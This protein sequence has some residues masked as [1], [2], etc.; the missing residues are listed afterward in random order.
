[1]KGGNLTR[2]C[3]SRDVSFRNVSVSATATL[4]IEA[5]ARVRFLVGTQ[6]LLSEGSSELE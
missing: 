4:Y 5:I 2:L 6:L 3:T 1:M